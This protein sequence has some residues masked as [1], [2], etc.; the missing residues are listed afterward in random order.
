LSHA[1]HE[2]Q[3][4]EADRETQHNDDSQN[5]N[6]EVPPVGRRGEV[7]ELVSPIRARSELVI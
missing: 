4:E 6:H 3:D 5:G 1:A 2:S 7:G